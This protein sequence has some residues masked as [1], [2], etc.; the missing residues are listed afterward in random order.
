MII[1][2]MFILQS[3]SFSKTL[4][5]RKALSELFMR[6]AWFFNYIIGKLS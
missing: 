4:F 5:H 3:G 2:I 6:Q 1:V